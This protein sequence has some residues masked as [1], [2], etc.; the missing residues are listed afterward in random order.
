MLRTLAIGFISLAV[1]APAS[2]AH[3]DPSLTEIEAQLDKQNKDL[4]ATIENYNKLNIDMADAQAKAADLEK[5]VADSSAGVQAIAIESFK[6]NGKMRN[7]N[8][9][10]NATSSGSLVDQM[11]MLQQ[12]T[13]QQQKAIEQYKSAKTELDKTIAAQNTQKADFENKRKQIEG[14]VKKLT[15]LQKKAKNAGSTKVTGAN[16]NPGPLP[17]VSGKAGAAVEYAKSKLNKPYK[18]SAAGPDAF[19]CSGLTMAAWAY[20]GV[21]LPHNAKD[22]WYSGKV[23]QFK[24]KS[25]LQPGDLVFYNGLGHVGIYVGNNTIIHAPHT[26]DVVRYAPIT[27]DSLY[28]YGRVKG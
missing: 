16:Y 26:G 25:Q 21:S 8:A 1:L 9:M 11:S 5:H 24:D 17:S 6:T 2:V 7:L 12:I 10:L 28:G 22:Q 13:R 23:Q 14:D 3:A 4:E 15:D 19:D 18:F 20:A 27:V